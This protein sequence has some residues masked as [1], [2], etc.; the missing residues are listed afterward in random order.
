MKKNTYNLLIE[1][2]NQDY[3]GLLDF[4]S[5]ECKYALVAIRDTIQLNSK[6][7]EFLEKLSKYLYEEKLAY[8]WPGTKL[9]NRQARIFL[10]HYVPA[11]VEILKEAV[12]SLYKWRQPDF[13]EDLC[14]L[15]ADETPW[16]VTI[17]HESDGFFILLDQEKNRL[18]SALPQYRSMIGP[19]CEN[20]AQVFRCSGA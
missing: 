2:G 11:S 8:E 16:L 5:T 7:Q 1:P 12:S 10:F 3:Y 6:G 18:F 4:A 19:P 13:P 20:G 15:R 9:L 17:S 14:L